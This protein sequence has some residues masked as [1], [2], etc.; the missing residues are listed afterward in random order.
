MRV[1]TNVCA[2]QYSIPGPK[3]SKS[4]C[5]TMPYLIFLLGFMNLNLLHTVGTKQN[6]FKEFPLFKFFMFG[7]SIE[8]L[9]YIINLHFSTVNWTDVD[10]PGVDDG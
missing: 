4:M 2:E 7:S 8:P 6:T 1:H 10:W 9:R 5:G 3:N